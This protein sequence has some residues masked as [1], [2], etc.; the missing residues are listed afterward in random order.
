[1]EQYPFQLMEIIDSEKQF[2][3]SILPDHCK[4]GIGTHLNGS[5]IGFGSNLFGTEI[6]SKTIPNF[7]WGESENRNTSNR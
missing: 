6:H 7:S 3:G 5:T 4:C 1:M 2:L